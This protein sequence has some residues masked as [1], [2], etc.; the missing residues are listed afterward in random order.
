M[1]G[2]FLKAARL[3]TLPLAIASIAMGAVLS[4]YFSRHSWTIT[5][6]ALVTA[7][8]LQILSNFANDYGDFAKGT[9]DET[10]TDRA[11]ASGEISLNQMRMALVVTALLALLSG[12][13]LLFVALEDISTSF[14]VFLIIGVVSIGAAIKYTAGK[15]PYGYKSWGDIS[16]FLFFGIVG[17]LGVYYLQT[18][19]IDRDFW[20]CL[21][22]ASAMGLLGAGVLN[23]NNIRDIH[24]DSENGKVTLAV[25]LG[26]QNAEKYQGFIYGLSLLL[27]I[28]FL[29]KVS[30]SN[31]LLILLLA[32]LY[33]FHW[34]KLKS[35]NNTKE[36]RPAYNRLLKIHV[37][38][39]LILVI[40]ITLILL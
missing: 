8:I 15:N 4:A 17:V 13:A 18:I 35:L 29:N 20:L 21:L 27:L 37:L 36:N 7:I 6:L 9:D 1:L 5:V 32:P 2:V 34:F 12:T 25:K 10:R 38:L 40:V 33:T 28:L 26:K 30:A 23:I 24:G 3:R 16:V 22:P 31:G 19:H 39:N 14:L 11:L